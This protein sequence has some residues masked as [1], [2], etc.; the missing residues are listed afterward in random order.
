[1][2]V[3]KHRTWLISYCISVRNLWLGYSFAVVLNA[4]ILLF[5]YFSLGWSPCTVAFAIMGPVILVCFFFRY[6][7][8]VREYSEEEVPT[9]N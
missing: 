4:L 7:Y 6:R 8:L 5:F 9:V 2:R 3:V 1:M